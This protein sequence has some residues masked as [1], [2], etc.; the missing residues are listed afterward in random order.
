MKNQS[1]EIEALRSA[2]NHQEELGRR[3]QRNRQKKQQS[4]KKGALEKEYHNHEK[5]L[6]RKNP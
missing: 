5:K 1:E 4:G 6:Q 3:G 2:N